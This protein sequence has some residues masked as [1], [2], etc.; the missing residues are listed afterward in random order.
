MTDRD[1]V[2][3]QRILNY[4]FKILLYSVLFIDVVF[5]VR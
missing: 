4:K 3:I 2:L 1:L 5:L